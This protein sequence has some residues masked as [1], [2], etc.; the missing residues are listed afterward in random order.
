MPLPALPSLP[1]LSFGRIVPVQLSRSEP[2]QAADSCQP[3]VDATTLNNL[4]PQI[5]DLYLSHTPQATAAQ[6]FVAPAWTFADYLIDRIPGVY[7]FHNLGTHLKA[8][9]LVEQLFQKGDAML[10]LVTDDQRDAPGAYGTTAL[11]AAIAGQ[12]QPELVVESGLG[13]AFSSQSHEAIAP[14]RL[15]TTAP[16]GALPN[17]TP[18]RLTQVS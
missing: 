18:L 17:N 5:A 6:P 1:S 16:A 2:S 12:S 14:F 9:A 8:Q 3:V 13:Q 10:V 4:G 7:A 11:K 15:Q